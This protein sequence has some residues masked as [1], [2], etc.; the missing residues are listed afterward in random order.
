MAVPFSQR[1]IAINVGKPNA[2]YPKVLYKNLIEIDEL[3]DENFR[4]SCILKVYQALTLV[5]ANP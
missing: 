5:Q 1:S 4:G 2:G 3:I